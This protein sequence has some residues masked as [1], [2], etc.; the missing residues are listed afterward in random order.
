MYKINHNRQ[1]KIEM[2]D[3]QA[4]RVVKLSFVV[5]R[6]AWKIDEKHNLLQL[7]F[8]LLLLKWVIVFTMNFK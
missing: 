6:I 4:K 2:E 5:K 7:G 3:M 8:L 1:K